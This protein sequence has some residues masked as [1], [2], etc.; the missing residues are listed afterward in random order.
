MQPCYLPI[1]MHEMRGVFGWGKGFVAF[2]ACTMAACDCGSGTSAVPCTTVEDCPAG[3]M[4]RDGY[5]APPADASS[6]P[7]SDA[8]GEAGR[9]GEMDGGMD[10]TAPECR[11]DEDCGDGRLC[12]G[13]ACCAAEA[14]CA[15]ECCDVAGGEVCFAG[16]CVL[17]GASCTR[18]ADCGEGAYCERGL[19]DDGGGMG[20]M[21]PPDDGRVCL[22]ETPA[23]GR[24]LAFPPSCDEPG[25]DPATCIRA[26]CEFVPS[27]DRLNATLQW[28]WG[29]V[30]D[31]PQ[32]GEVAPEAFP[33][34]IDVA[35]TPIVGR[36][37]DTNCDGSV[38]ERDPPTVV[39]VSTNA[40]GTCCSCSGAEQSCRNGV[41]RALDG[42][43]GRELWSLQRAY[44]GSRG[45]AT[46][47]Q[48]LG[49]VDGDGA[50][51]V[52]ALTGERR[53]VVIE[54]DGT[55]AAV[56]EDAVEAPGN[57]NSFGWGGGIALG[58]MEGDGVVEFAYGRD[59]F[60]YRD[61]AIVRRWRGSARRGGA[62]NWALSILADVD[63]DG[64]LELVAGPTAYE[65]DGSI[66]W[67]TTSVQDGFPAVADFDG[68]G[69]PEVV[70]V[71]QPSAGVSGR[72]VFLEGATGA[73]KW[74]PLQLGGRGRGGPPTVADFDG[75]GR[76]EV[77]VAQADYY[78]LV[79]VEPDD[80]PVLSIKWRA[81]THDYSS[82]VTGSTVFDFEGDGR[83][84]VVYNDE[85]FLWV[86][87][88]TDGSV[89]FTA[90]TTSYTATEASLVADVDGDGHAEIVVPSNGANPNTWT[91]AH[92]QAGRPPPAPPHGPLPPEAVWAPGPGPRGTWRGVS[93]WRDAENSWVG[94]R[95][96]WNQHSYHVTNI[97]SDRDSACD[98]PRSYGAIPAS[99]RPNWSI[100]WLDNFRQNVQESGLF[101]AP[102]ATVSLRALCQEPPVLLAS[103]R[104][105]GR[106]VLPAGVQVGFYLVQDDGTEVRLGGEATSR[107]LAPGQAE[108]LRFETPVGT[109]V[110]A[111]FV[112][113]IEVD[114]MA[115][116]FRE[117]DEENNASEVVSPTC[118]G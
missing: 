25:A 24:C 102:D 29:A 57:P 49:D 36:L 58:D 61:G 33:G 50:M 39:F 80:S 18:D 23:P 117:C 94:T 86:Y 78:S 52:V 105:R 118:L 99:E 73:V 81:P 44:D 113:R 37:Y 10:A 85:C 40:N 87:D 11:L 4:C 51:E 64:A 93:V 112:A 101:D 71:Y 26:E 5:C 27:F 1:M 43:S 98:P 45:F 16:A 100:D 15:G 30:H 32:P 12:L 95:T 63:G 62:V 75:D 38:D 90:P 115:R 19:V 108:E 41:L 103:V 77:G 92:H 96:L 79:D 46:L 116:T 70:V 107:A 68:D 60:E 54:G 34:R 82:S 20:G 2:M 14:V 31:P 111:R 114:P 69:A 48:A 22:G 9:D 13:G 47:T 72:V 21:D 3:Q 7:P 8:G 74:G 84:E 110:T 91:C 59:L 28:R 35:S 55:V 6:P 65:A 56:S 104:N 106:A 66:L 17:P 89:R 97:C 88:G 83:A 53:F 67:N 109:S 76:P 42:A